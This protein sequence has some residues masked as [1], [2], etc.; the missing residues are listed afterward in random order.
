MGERVATCEVES[1]LGTVRLA[2]TGRGLVR[3]ALPGGASK[4]FDGWLRREL[5]DVER[6]PGLGVLDEAAD[7]LRGYFGGQ[8]REFK[9]KL[10]LRGTEFQK[11]VWH[12]LSKIPYG[13][14]RSYGELARM[15]G[16]PRAQ[17]AVGAA[18]G[19]NPVPIV[20][21]CHRVIEASGRIG[22]Y[23]AGLDNKRFLLAFEQ[24]AAH[25]HQLL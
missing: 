23:S 15:V 8:L 11:S 6:V 5:G 14:T 10:D 1:P 19:M 3:I 20:I 18:N 9:V 7:E 21:P 22:G 12:Q 17:R 16:R 24:N 13:E 25:P 4:A 2:A